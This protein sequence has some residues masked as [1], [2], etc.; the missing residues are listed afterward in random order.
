MMSAKKLFA[1]SIFLLTL[2]S[3]VVGI[4]QEK[5][6]M[7]VPPDKLKAAFTDANIVF[8]GKVVEADLTDGNFPGYYGIHAKRVV[9]EVVGPVKG[10]PGKQVETW[11]M[12]QP[13]ETPEYLDPIKRPNAGPKLDPKLF[14]KGS[15]HVVYGLSEKMAA[16]RWKLSISFVYDAGKAGDRVFGL[17]ITPDVESAKAAAKNQAG[18]ANG[19]DQKMEG[20]AIDVR[21]IELKEIAFPFDGNIKGKMM[22]EITTPEQLAKEFPKAEW[23]AQIK[24]EVDFAKQKLVF[25]AWSYSKADQLTV[26]AERDDT[27]PFLNFHLA[28]SPLR[29]ELADNR[30]LFAVPL[31]ARCNM[32]VT[33]P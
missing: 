10:K 16:G 1:M 12:L 27:G 25:N 32:R 13:L 26:T 2:S 15:V 23:Q 22:V 3:G 18:G 33:K 4:A 8:E 5:P 6:P 11:L 24:K 20:K 9:Y 19:Q 29:G 21:P 17:M 31:D 7:R 28:F 30:Y 14:A